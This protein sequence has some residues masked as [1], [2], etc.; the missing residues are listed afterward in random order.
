[1]IRSRST[2]LGLGL[3]CDWPH[4]YSNYFRDGKSWSLP[5]C[6]SS[7]VEAFC[8]K[9]AI[10]FFG[11]LFALILTLTCKDALGRFPH[12]NTFLA[13][14]AWQY[15]LLFCNWVWFLP[16]IN[17]TGVVRFR[18]KSDSLVLLQIRIF[19]FYIAFATII[20]WYMTNYKYLTYS[21][22][23]NHIVLFLMG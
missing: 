3:L 18:A 19:W 16:C 15:Q 23:I 5:V 10:K 2:S 17:D 9:Q 6:I 20:N 4:F 14:E 7:Y 8:I 12:N 21:T 1:M 13:V 22:L 11:L